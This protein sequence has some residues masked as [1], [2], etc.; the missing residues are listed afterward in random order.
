[1]RRLTLTAATMC[2]FAMW[3]PAVG[4]DTAAYRIIPDHYFFTARCA[5]YRHALPTKTA[6]AAVLRQLNAACGRL[7][8]TPFDGTRATADFNR[9]GES[10]VQLQATSDPTFDPRKFLHPERLEALKRSYALYTI[11]LLNSKLSFDDTQDLADTIAAFRDFGDS[12]EIGDNRAAIWLSVKGQDREP[13]VAWSRRICDHLGLS[14]C[15]STSYIVL[16]DKRPDL[17]KPGDRRC[18]ISF[19]NLSVAGLKKLLIDL[20]RER[21]V[22]TQLR[23]DLASLALRFSGY[24]RSKDAPPGLKVQKD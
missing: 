3:S 22:P 1:M 4:D 7:A 19:T 11:L 9:I 16:T 15:I 24:A 2:V 20:E 8:S 10:L 14:D 12:K 17:W 23:Y 6:Y 13:D 18:R 21:T 5:Y